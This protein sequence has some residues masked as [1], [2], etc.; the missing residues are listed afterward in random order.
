MTMLA[1]TGA[2]VG[3]ANA[4][5]VLLEPREGQRGLAIDRAVHRLRVSRVEARIEVIGCR[6]PV[7]LGEPDS[8]YSPDGAGGYRLRRVLAQGQVS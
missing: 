5:E 3:R 1:K 8:E 7:R 4:P 2:L 6:N